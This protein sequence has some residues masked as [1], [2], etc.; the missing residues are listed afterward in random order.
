[1]V[2]KGRAALQGNMEKFPERSRPD[3]LPPRD[4]SHLTLPVEVRWRLRKAAAAKEVAVDTVALA[5][6][7]S[8]LDALDQEWEQI[9]NLK[10][11]DKK[12]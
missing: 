8:Y 2:R 10:D 11:D 7:Q 5:A 6:I 1:M 3:K 12:Q 9:Q 4:P